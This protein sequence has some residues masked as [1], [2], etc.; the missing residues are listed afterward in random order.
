MAEDAQSGSCGLNVS[1][2]DSAGVS[3]RLVGVTAV[4]V[5]LPGVW[6]VNERLVDAAAVKV[7]LVGVWAVNESAVRPASLGLTTR[8]R[9]MGAA[10]NLTSSDPTNRCA[11][12]SPVE[13]VPIVPETAS[14]PDDTA[15][16]PALTAREPMPGAP[17]MDSEV[18]PVADMLLMS[19]VEPEGT[20]PA[21]PPPPQKSEP[22]GGWL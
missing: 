16:D 17:V 1:E 8:R 13:P 5:R 9:D 15:K 19:N 22:V 20:S 4:K 2:P 12:A 14:E 11:G 21:P 7:R 18:V 3:V 10:Q 6:S